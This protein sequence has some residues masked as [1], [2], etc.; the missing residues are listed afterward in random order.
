MI[1]SVDFPRKDFLDAAPL[2]HKSWYGLL[3]LSVF[4]PKFLFH[5]SLLFFG[6]PVVEE[7]ENGPQQQRRERDP[8][9]VNARGEQDKPKVL[10]VTCLSVYAR[11]HQLA[12]RSIDSS[13]AEDYEENS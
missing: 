1:N 13:P 7:H 8:E 3:I 12:F 9:K 10:R 11:R 6:K 5:P 2:W 4:F